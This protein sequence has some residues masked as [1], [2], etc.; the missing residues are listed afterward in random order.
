MMSV[1]K[2]PY[3]RGEVWAES[4]NLRGIS[5]GKKTTVSAFS[6]GAV[7]IQH[8]NVKVQKGLKAQWKVQWTGLYQRCENQD[9]RLKT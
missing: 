9:V 8:W 2:E 7:F 1:G 4:Q 5:I 6:K 3:Q